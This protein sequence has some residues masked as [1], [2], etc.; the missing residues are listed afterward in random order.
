[1]SKVLQIGTIIPIVTET[2]DMLRNPQ[3]TG[4]QAFLL[5]GRK[6]DVDILRRRLGPVR[7]GDEVLLILSSQARVARLFALTSV[8]SD[9]RRDIR[10]EAALSA[11]TGS[12]RLFK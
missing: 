6:L 2:V 3:C 11:I 5:P 10:T 8:L 1:M 7:P 4:F 9:W 12:V